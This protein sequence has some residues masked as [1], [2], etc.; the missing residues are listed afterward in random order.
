[1]VLQ[2][3]LLISDSPANTAFAAIPLMPAYSCCAT[4][5]AALAI[6]IPVMV[7]MVKVTDLSTPAAF[8]IFPTVILLPELAADLA[9]ATVPLMLTAGDG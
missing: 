4:P 7:W 5:A 2:N 1:M 6:G 9:F 3:M 8:A